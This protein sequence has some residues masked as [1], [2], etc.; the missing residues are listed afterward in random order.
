VA[1]PALQAAFFCTLVAA[2]SEHAYAYAALLPPAV[3]PCLQLM[4]AYD[5]VLL[6]AMQVSELVQHLRHARQMQR[7]PCNPARELSASL[8]M[9]QLRCRYIENYIAYMVQHI[10][11]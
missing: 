5:A 11:A 3:E 8:L 2:T 4:P 10:C 6:L 1:V 7:L 9:Q